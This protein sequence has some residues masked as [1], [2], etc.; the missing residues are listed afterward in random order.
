MATESI[1][2][3]VNGTIFFVQTNNFIGHL[4][5]PLVYQSLGGEE[6][7]RIVDN[8]NN[9]LKIDTTI[10]TI[11]GV[12]FVGG[13]AQLQTDISN[14]VDAANTTFVNFNSAVA[15]GSATAAKQD[16]QTALLGKV[17]FFTNVALGR[18]TGAKN[19]KK[20]GENTVVSTTQLPLN[21][22][23]SPIVPLTVAATISF[24]SNSANDTVAGTGARYIRIFGVNSSGA[25][26]QEDL[27]LNGTT[28]VT[29]INSYYG[30]LNRVI[31]TQ[32]GSGATKSNQGTITGTSGG[33]T[34]CTITIGD[35][36]MKQLAYYV[37]TNK[38]ALIY[39]YLFDASKNAGA[40]VVFDVFFYV[41]QGGVKYDLFS[42]K[43]DQANGI[44]NSSDRTYKSPLPIP[45]GCLWWAECK[46]SAG[47]AIL[48]AEVEQI[49]FDNI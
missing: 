24:V 8:F 18:V 26:I 21:E 43:I 14:A 16:E 34:Y 19:W 44:D 11:N 29:T 33:N 47:T 35:S 40:N 17:E 28:P 27:A 7:V 31:V 23:G 15:G 37:P 25:E 39:S 46:V 3:L 41:L 45:Q 49:I 32:V 6:F 38:T 4:F 1:K 12:A 5:P 42:F 30:I 20:T 22:A 10:S 13:L 9:V 36:V 48:T 2:T